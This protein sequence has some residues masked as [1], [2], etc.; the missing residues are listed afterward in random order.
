MS[1]IDEMRRRRE[2][3]YSQ[4]QRER[5]HAS[6][7]PKIVEVAVDVEPQHPANDAN[8]TADKDAAPE[9]K[10]AVCGKTKALQNWLLV[11]HQKGLGKRCTGSRQPPR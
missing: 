5:Q 11:S 7:S 6:K 2:A 9:G 8:K 1:K 10:C 3:Q 4:Q